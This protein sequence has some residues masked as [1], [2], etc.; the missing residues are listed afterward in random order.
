MLPLKLLQPLQTGCTFFFG[1]QRHQLE[2]WGW[3]NTMICIQIVHPKLN[4][5]LLCLLMWERPWQMTL[6]TYRR[7]VI[8]YHRLSQGSCKI[9]ILWTMMRLMGC[10]KNIDFYKKVQKFIN[11]YTLNS[12]FKNSLH[13]S[14][15]EK[16][17]DEKEIYASEITT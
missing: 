2:T 6:Q 5:I 1:E 15:F 17:T 13:T 14:F 7:C 10:P 16:I 8:L 11:S 3:Q 4:L 12:F 9:I